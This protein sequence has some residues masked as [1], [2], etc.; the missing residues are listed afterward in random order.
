MIIGLVGPFLLWGERNGKLGH[1]VLP[2]DG[3][4]YNIIVIHHHHHHD[5][6]HHDHHYHHHERV[7]IYV[8]LSASYL[9]TTHTYNTNNT[10]LYYPINDVV[11]QQHSTLPCVVTRNRSIGVVI[12]FYSSCIILCYI[13]TSF[14]V[15]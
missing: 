9:P 6:V 10:I 14:I 5:H 11:E 4:Y 12:V 2:S 3:R 8:C 13:S 1:V 15:Y 7:V